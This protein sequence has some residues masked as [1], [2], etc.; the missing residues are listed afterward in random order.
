MSHVTLRDER[1][2][3]RNGVQGVC[4]HGFYLDVYWYYIVKI[5]DSYHFKSGNRPN[6]GIV[7]IMTTFRVTMWFRPKTKNQK[8]A[9]TVENRAQRGVPKRTKAGASSLSPLCL[10]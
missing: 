4:A 8:Q 9:D 5:G 7:Q 2:F 1:K 10:P 6:G 3:S